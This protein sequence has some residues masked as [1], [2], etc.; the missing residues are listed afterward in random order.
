MIVGALRMDLHVAGASTLK[1]KRR[2]VASIKARLRQQFNVSVSEL[3]TRDVCQRC[4]LAVAM[5]SDSSRDIQSE[6]DKIV[7]V[8]RGSRGATL[9]D[10]TS[11]ML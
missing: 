9:L 3:N 10:Y 5:V 6:L 1:D 2:V 11:S 7:D 8:V 4:D